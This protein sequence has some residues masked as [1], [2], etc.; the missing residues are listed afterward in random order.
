MRR[1]LCPNCDSERCIRYGKITNKGEIKQRWRCKSCGTT[2]V[3]PDQCHPREYQEKYDIPNRPICPFCEA[4]YETE[5]R[6]TPTQFGKKH[7]RFRCFMCSFSSRYPN[8][9]TG[10]TDDILNRTHGKI[11]NY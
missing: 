8:E 5:V 7:T 1:P 6:M 2:F 3:Q 10:I 11:H 4:D 9:Y